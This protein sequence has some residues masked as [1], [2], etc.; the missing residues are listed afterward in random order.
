MIL[1]FNART[2][3][4]YLIMKTIRKKNATDILKPLAWGG[5]VWRQQPAVQEGK[6]ME[7]Q[8]GSAGGGL[9]KRERRRG[10]AA[11]LVGHCLGPTQLLPTL[12]WCHPFYWAWQ[13]GMSAGFG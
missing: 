1:K 7:G 13:E 3:P 8:R 4:F 10:P 6:K 12:H 5:L 2:L 11:N 9:W